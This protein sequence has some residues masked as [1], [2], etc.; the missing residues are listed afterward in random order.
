[1]LF[2]TLKF[3]KFE[4]MMTLLLKKIFK[5]CELLKSLMKKMKYNN[6]TFRIVKISINQNV[7]LI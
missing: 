2:K 6:S 1:M 3:L 4:F 7:F 5:Q